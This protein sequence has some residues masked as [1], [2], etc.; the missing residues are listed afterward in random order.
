M[1]QLSHAIL[2]WD[3]DDLT[4]LKTAKRPKMISNNIPEPSEQNVIE[5]LARKEMTFH[6]RRTMLGAEETIL[7]IKCL[8]VIV[9]EIRWGY[10]IFPWAHLVD[11]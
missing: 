4:L 8:M 11:M 10:I 6:C 7:M 3:R 2:K 5:R 9:V 1:N